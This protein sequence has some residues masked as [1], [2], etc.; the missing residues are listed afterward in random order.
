MDLLTIL[1]DA[2]ENPWI[3]LPLLFVFAV[4]A[5]V[6]L[7]IPVEVG[8]LNPW[9]SPLALILVLGLGK[10]VGACLVLPLGGWVGARIEREVAR[11]P[12]FARMY[13]RLKQ[14]IAH[15][16]YVAL[17]AIL[18]IP[19]MSDT[20]PIY[21]FS[22]MTGATRDPSAASGAPQRKRRPSAPP[23]R[24]GPFVLVSFAAG[25]VRGSLFLAIPIL[26]GWP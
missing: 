10:A 14:G 2:A 13:A 19:F 7:P 3:Y 23:L 8:L 1:T 11:Y 6:A 12:R 16:G 26:L 15:W 21:A 9:I 18:S 5:T 25:L 4:A 22:T 24:R 20:A 17:F